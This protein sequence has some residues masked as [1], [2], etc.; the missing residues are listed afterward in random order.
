MSETTP[1]AAARHDLHALCDRLGLGRDIA[2][3][4]HWSAAADFLQLIVDHALTEKTET[5][6][7]CSSGATT[8]MLARCC[9]RNGRGKVFSLENGAEFAANTRAELVRFGL[10]PWAQVIDAP[11]IERNIEARTFQWY[12]LDR[13][14]ERPIDMLVI[15]GPPGF[16]QR[17]SRYPALPLLFDR[18][19]EGATVFLDD[20]A[21][22][23]E[24]ELVAAWLRAYP[25][26]T[27]RYIAAERGCSILR[28]TGRS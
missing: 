12:A 17:H 2:Y 7:E 1:P 20:A 21:R 25:A 4:D 14:P 13:L 18:L 27:H 22:P 23:D 26:L 10:E 8:L 3:D 6:V 9:E 24:Q 11:L 16:L 19:A 15:D 28:K 5:V